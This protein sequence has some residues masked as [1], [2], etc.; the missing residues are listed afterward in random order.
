M[1]GL[2]YIVFANFRIAGSGVETENSLY[3]CIACSAGIADAEMPAL[4]DDLKWVT[5]SW[6]ESLY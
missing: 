3:P 2:S 6:Y 5:V 1:S 4:T